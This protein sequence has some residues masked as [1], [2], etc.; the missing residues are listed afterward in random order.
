MPTNINTM[1]PVKR[2][3]SCVPQKNTPGSNLAFESRKKKKPG[4]PT[5][6]D[7]ADNNSITFDKSNKRN[8]NG[9]ESNGKLQCNDTNIH[10]QIRS[11]SPTLHDK[12]T[13]PYDN[14]I[15][16]IKKSS[17]HLPHVDNECYEITSPIISGK[18]DIAVAK[19]YAT[20]T[21]HSMGVLDN[22]MSKLGI[23]R[24]DAIIHL[25]TGAATS[26][27]CSNN[28]K[29]ALDDK[30]AECESLAADILTLMTYRL[31][32]I[33]NKQ[34]GNKVDVDL[35]LDM[36]KDLHMRNNV[37]D[38][39]NSSDNMDTEEDDSSSSILSSP[40]TSDPITENNNNDSQEEIRVSSEAS[41]FEVVGIDETGNDSFDVEL[42]ESNNDTDTRV[43]GSFVGSSTSQL[44]VFGEMTTSDEGRIND[45]AAVGLDESITTAAQDDGM[46]L[47]DAPQVQGRNK[48][49][50]R[51]AV[52]KLHK[53]FHNLELPDCSK[54]ISQY[55]PDEQQIA[56]QTSLL[57]ALEC[58][59]DLPEDLVEELMS[60]VD[61]GYVFFHGQCK[62]YLYTLI[63]SRET[64]CFS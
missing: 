29:S 1:P 39:I 26:N 19:H 15:L 11:V 22:M 43:E 41:T 16:A 47:E 28:T 51:D 56:E 24:M 46:T 50:E 10:S 30:N 3:T 45:T 14:L 32:K 5:S 7:I 31:D 44:V 12:N 13:L 36:M 52:T 59:L 27:S 21:T 49:W 23:N 34:E 63:S 53:I 48:E 6:F 25:F 62:Y 37:E 42:T 33:N 20:I 2:G 40:S 54:I 64:I 8:K 61:M 57:F 38:D 55:T 60:L 4:N 35:L 17:Q 18:D 9:I 58:H